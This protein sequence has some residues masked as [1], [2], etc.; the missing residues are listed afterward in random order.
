MGV[1]SGESKV[2]CYKE[3]Y[4]IGTWNV[5][6]MNQGKLDVVKQEIARLTEDLR[7]QSTKKDENGWI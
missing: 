7:N 1:S 2:C 6:S 3:Q 4:F 5:S